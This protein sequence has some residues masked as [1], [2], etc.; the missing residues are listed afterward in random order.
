M[1]M[2]DLTEL[3]KGLSKIGAKNF[4]GV[5]FKLRTSKPPFLYLI[6]THLVPKPSISCISF[7]PAF[8]LLLTGK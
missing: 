8:Y 7:A 3:S 2:G 6:N 4:E 5:C 1:E